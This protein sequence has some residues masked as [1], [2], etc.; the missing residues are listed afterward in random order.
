MKITSLNNPMQCRKD[1]QIYLKA[2][3]SKEQFTLSWKGASYLIVV[4]ILLLR[5]SICPQSVPFS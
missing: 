5:I 3:S 4:Q 1:A 2:Q